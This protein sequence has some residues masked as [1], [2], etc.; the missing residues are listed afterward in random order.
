[1]ESIFR[2][3]NIFNNWFLEEK[4][5]KKFFQQL[6]QWNCALYASELGLSLAGESP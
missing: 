6:K 2:V 1:M 4:K 3:K 5:I